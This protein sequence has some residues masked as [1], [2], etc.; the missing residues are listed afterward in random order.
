[1]KSSLIIA[2]VIAGLGLLFF[3]GGA[4]KKNSPQTEKNQAAGV[5]YAEEPSF[6][7][8]VISMKS[9]KVSHIFAIENQSDEPSVLRSIATS[10]MCTEAFVVDGENQRGPFGMPGHGSAALANEVI[11][12]RE[13][14]DIKVVFDPAAHG[15]SGIG[16]IERAV[17]LEGGDG[18]EKVLT[19]KA[20]VIP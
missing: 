15:P 6:D 20:T 10:C 11:P 8:G 2:A 16:K 19:I 12:P 9:G 13:T 3:A 17:F 5:L 18:G 14:R 1:M 4:A 7:F